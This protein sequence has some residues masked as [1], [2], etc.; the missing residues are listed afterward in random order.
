MTNHQTRDP[1]SGELRGDRFPPDALITQVK[2][3]A[4]NQVLETSGD[5][6]AL[7]GWGDND[8]VGHLAQ[9]LI[10]PDDLPHLATVLS[11][12]PSPPPAAI[13]L[14]LQHR[15]MGWRPIEVIPLARSEGA[16]CELQ[17]VG[18]PAG[19]LANPKVVQPA[20]ES[21]RPG[22][23][24]ELGDASPAFI[25]DLQDQFI[26]ENTAANTLMHP[27]AIAAP[28]VSMQEWLNQYEIRPVGT[29][30]SD[31]SVETILKDLPWQG[32]VQAR[33][34]GHARVF[35]LAASQITLENTSAAV[36]LQLYERSSFPAQASGDSVTA[37]S[38]SALVVEFR[39]IMG[40]ISG[41]ANLLS[42]TLAQENIDSPSM[43]R[44]TDFSA[45]AIRLLTPMTLLAHLD[46]LDEISFK[47][48]QALT[49]LSPL[50][51]LLSF[52]RFQLKTTPEAEALS[53]LGI[54]G[55]F[56]RAMIATVVAIG[57]VLK[58]DGQISFSCESQNTHF[59]LSIEVTNGNLDLMPTP[60][61]NL[62]ADSIWEQ[63]FPT[64]FGLIEGD[65]NS[66]TASA[67][68]TGVI[69]QLLLAS[70][71]AA[72]PAPSS[73][74]TKA[75]LPRAV[76]QALLIEDDEGVRDL[77]D[78]FLGSLGM[79][80]TS[81]ASEQ[82]VR[83]LKSMDFDLIVSDVML[84]TGKTGPTLVRAIREQQPNIPCLFISG[85]KQGALSED[86]LAVPNTDF[87]AKPFTKASFTE[88]IS[89]LM[90]E[91]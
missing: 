18:Y 55:A 76:P 80:V 74:D 32:D 29:Q 46:D 68:E 63:R 51:T 65:A 8:F 70:N 5:M 67:T 64:L 79:D 11:R 54:P 85:Y 10:H 49:D 89:R 36:L 48:A 47:P 43:M 78:L 16:H 88:R 66:L 60:T 57:D 34:F 71:P 37:T 84:A 1:S 27:A 40:V 22:K 77:V 56:D 12:D 72:H 33:I 38:L 7:T 25:F 39:N 28:Y 17:F 41:H 69:L 42:E 2:L 83:A 35:F 58:T 24:F 30:V 23:F 44:V 4:L 86:D 50:L 91:A 19:V 62:Q 53:I 45:E 9:E 90:N 31:F 6:H 75:A 73:I 21:I 13:V 61:S 82:D 81:C 59:D 52:N 20:V 87:L 15:E 14:R 3:N 26:W